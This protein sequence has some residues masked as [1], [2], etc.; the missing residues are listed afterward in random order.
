M[1]KSWKDVS[2]NRIVKEIKYEIIKPQKIRIYT[3]FSILNSEEPLEI[4]YLIYGNGDVIIK[5]MIRPNKNMVRF[6]MQ[7]SISKEY[8]I[9]KWFGRGPHETMWD[10]KTGAAI[11]IYSGLVKD[12]IH[13]YIR[14]QENGN[15]TDVR[16][17]AMINKEGNGLLISDIEGTLLNTSAWPYTMEDL[18]SANYNHNL[19]YR[20]YITFNID[21]KQQG[22]GGDMPGLA[23]IHKKYLLKA[24]ILYT[25]SFRLR[26][27]T[28]EMGEINVVAR[29]IPDLMDF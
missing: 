17:V 22:V 6:G 14:P 21:Y 27:Y 28:K 23:L 7:T 20:D 8:N 18:E 26:G 5:N 3:K 24:H 25:Y 15:R 19:P 1:D 29:Q 4:L 13:P 16:W 12:L 9:M 10:R 2:K 11:G